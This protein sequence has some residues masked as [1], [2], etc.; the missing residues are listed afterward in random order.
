M[1]YVIVKV[2]GKELPIIVANEIDLDT[3]NL[4]GPIVSAGVA[5]VQTMFITCQGTQTI[6]GKEYGSRGMA[7]EILLRMS[8]HID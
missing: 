7:D 6:A 1:K 5:K 8:D 2:D 3:L 4:P